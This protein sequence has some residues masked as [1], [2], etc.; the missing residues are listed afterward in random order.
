MQLKKLLLLLLIHTGLMPVKAQAI[1][2]DEKR[3]LT[4]DDF[5]AYP[6][7][8]GSGSVTYWGTAY[9]YKCVFSDCDY[10]LTFNIKNEFYPQ[11][12]WVWW[13]QRNEY[14]LG[15]EQLHFDI[16]ELYTRK[17]AAALYSAVYT[18]NFKAEVEKIYND[19]MS[20]CAK[21]ESKYDAE[22]NHAGN[23]NMQYRWQLFIYLQLRALPRN[24]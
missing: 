7:H 18:E 11:A 5:K 9:D 8:D 16:N 6:Q 20:E 22:T 19:T 13:N 10:L 14:L 2:W 24:Y 23:V 1:K 4:W 17:L 3:P 12:S 15:H 21:M